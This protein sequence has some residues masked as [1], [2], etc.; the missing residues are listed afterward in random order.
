M[1]PK[2]T[3]KNCLYFFFYLLRAAWSLKLNKGRINQSV[4]CYETDF[5]LNILHV[6]VLIVGTNFSQLSGQN[7]FSNLRAF[8]SHTICR[9][10][11]FHGVFQDSLLLCD[12]RSLF[13]N[14]PLYKLL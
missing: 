9:K 2:L 5:C 3:V 13:R 12:T 7:L 11:C 8:K 1:K 4:D 10:H 6:C 14:L